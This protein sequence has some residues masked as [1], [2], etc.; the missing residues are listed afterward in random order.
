[1]ALMAISTAAQEVNKLYLGNISCM[2]GQTVDLAFFV[3][4]TSPNITAIQADITLPKGM[5]MQ[6]AES[7]ATLEESRVSDHRVKVQV[8]SNVD[9]VYRY[10]VMLLSPSNSTILANKGKVF[11]MQTMV[12]DA[13]PM[14]EGESYPILMQGVV[15]SN[16]EGQ[17]IVTAYEGGSIT[18]APS[19]DFTVSDVQLT[20]VNDQTGVTALSPGDNFTLSR[21]VNNIGSAQSEAGWNEQIILVSTTTGERCNVATSRHA[22]VRLESGASMEI[23]ENFTVPRLPG[24]DGPFNVLVELTPNSQSG[25]HTEY[26]HNNSA[27]TS[28]TYTMSKR[29]YLSLQQTDIAEPGNGSNRRYYATLE[30]S[31]SRRQQITFDVGYNPTDSRLTL[32]NGTVTISQSSSSA[33]FGFLVADDTQLNGDVVDFG[34]TVAAAAGYGA[35]SVGGHLIDDEHPDLLVSLPKTEFFEGDEFA[36]TITAT[37]APEEDLTIQLSNSAAS[38]FKMP[39]SGVTMAA[40]TTTA[41]AAIKVYDDDV[42]ADVIDVRFT[43][44]ASN[45]NSGHADAILHDNDMPNITLTLNTNAVSEGAGPNAVAC[46]LSR[47]KTNSQLTIEVST[48]DNTQLYSSYRRFTMAKGKSQFPFYLHMLDNGMM[49]GD[50]EVT[51]TVKA[52]IASCGCTTNGTVGG[53]AQ[54]TLTI[55]DDDGPALKLTASTPNIQEGSSGNKFTVSRNNELPSAITV[56]LSTDINNTDFHFPSTVTIPAGERSTTFE[57][58]LDRNSTSGDSRAITLVAKADGYSQGSC[59]VMATDQ[60]LADATI[61]MSV[62]TTEV[63]ATIPSVLNLTLH[64]Q[65]YAPLPAKTPVSIVAGGSVV[66]TVYTDEAFAAGEQTMMPIMLT[67]VLSEN[68]GTVEVFAVVNNGN[69]KPEINYGNNTSEKVTV[70][71]LPLLTT[72]ELHTDK[73]VYTS[74]ETVIISGQTE[75]RINREVDL[76][77]YIVQGGT[78]LPIMTKT[79]EEGHFRVEWTPTLGM[80][81]DFGIGACM[82]GEKLTT[83]STTIKLYGMRRASGTFL[84]SEMEVNEAK[85]GH[86]EIVNP[87]TMPLTNIHATVS[88]LANNV[89]LEV[90]D[91]ESL[92]PNETKVMNYR[93]TG[94]APSPSF[95]EWQTADLRITSAEG[96]VLPQT[97][98][99]VIYPAVPQLKATISSINTTMIKDETRN[100]EFTIYNEGRKETGEINVDVGNTQWLSTATPRRMASLAPGESATVVLQMRPTPGMEL[101]SI[102]TGNIYLSAANGSGVSIAMRV[103]CVSDNT[104]TLVVDVWDEFTANTEEAPHVSGATVAVLHPVTQKLL[105]QYVTGDDGLATFEDLPEGKYLVKVT[106]PKHESYSET[107]IVSPARTITQRAFIPYSA[108]TIEMVYEPTEVE[109]VYDIVT[110][111]NYETQVPRPVLKMDM[112]EKLMVEELQLPYIYYVTLTN[113]GLIAAKDVKFATKTEWG[114][115]RFTPLI[116]GPWEILPQQSVIIPVEITGVNDGSAQSRGAWGP[117]RGPISDKI[118]EAGV[119]CAM[120]T[121]ARYKGQCAA[122]ATNSSMTEYQVEKMMQVNEGCAGIADLVDMISYAFTVLGFSPSGSWSASA[123]TGSGSFH[124]QGSGITSVSCDPCLNDKSKEYIEALTNMKGGGKREMAES[125]GTLLA[126]CP[127]PPPD[128]PPLTAD[129]SRIKDQRHSPKLN[130]GVVMYNTDMRN[131]DNGTMMD[132]YREIVKAI[133]P[134]EDEVIE[135][136]GLVNITNAT[137]EIPSWQPSYLKAWMLNTGIAHDLNYHDLGYIFYVMGDTRLPIIETDE[138][139]AL[140][141]LFQ[142]GETPSDEQ[143]AALHPTALDDEQYAAVVAHLQSFSSNDFDKLSQLAARV[144]SDLMEINRKGYSNAKELCVAEADQTLEGLSSKQSSVCASV[145]LQISQRLT[146]TRQAVRGTLTVV[147]GSEDQPMSDIRLNLVVTDP[148]GN[149]ATPHIMEIHTESIN[150][151]TGELD[152]HSGW[153]LAAKQTG[154]AKIIF[155][156]TK[157]AA[158]TEPL[159]YTFAGTITFIDP[160][161]GLEMT[162]ELETERLTVAPSPDLDLTYFMQRD[163]L[164]DDPLTPEVE[165]Q[166]PS[167]FT[168]LINNKGYGD[169]TKVKMVTNQPEIIENEKGLL[170]DFEIISSQL[171]GGDK[172]LAMGSSVATDFGDIPAHSQAYAQWWMTSTLT[173]HF[174]D[175]SVE[176]THVTSYDNPDLSLLDEVTIH[177]LIHQIVIPGGEGS[178]PPLIGF[179]ANDEEDANDLPDQLYLSNGTKQ[180]VHQAY[181]AVATRESDTQ[182]TITANVNTAGWNYGSLTD[183]TGGSRKLLTVKRRDG[184]LL[185]AENFWQTDR[186]LRDGLQPLYENRIHFCDEMPIDGETYTVTFEDKPAVVLAVGSVSGIPSSDSFTREPVTEVVVTFNKPINAASFT[187]EDLVVMHEG[188]AVDLSGI[189]VEPIDT[190]NETTFKIGLG[191]ITTLD[192]YY[193]LDIQTAGISDLEGFFGEAGKKCSWIQLTDGKAN[194][195]MKVTPEGAGTVAPGTSKQDFNGIVDIAALPAEGYNF[196]HWVK[197][198]ALL[199][200]Q[201]SHSYQMAGPAT[202]TA[203][204]TPKQYRLIVNYNQDGGTIDGGSGLY[205][206]NQTVTLKA[207]AK[208]GYYFAGW[209][210]DG[211]IV[212]QDETLE[213]TIKKADAYEAVFELLS[214]VQA[215]LS[216]LNTKDENLSFFHNPKG[217]YYKVTLDRVLTKGQWNTFCVPFDI[218]EQQINKTWGYNTM[219]VQLKSVADA[220]LSFEYAWN[221]KAGV[222][223]LV[224]PER[225]VEH[226]ELEYKGNL[227]LQTDPLPSTYDNYTFVGNYGPHAW[228]ADGTEWY[229]GVKRGVLF[230]ASQATAHLNGFRAYFILPADGT[231]RLSIMGVA[232]DGIG[233]LPTAEMSAGRTAVY[234]VQGLYMGDDTKTLP[235][236]LYIVNG[237]KMVVK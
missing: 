233:E 43:A 169:A 215:D 71:V 23:T 217:E 232:T 225:T 188:E 194:L 17:N 65:G 202:L 109:D 191:S 171:N 156:P 31:G 180:T 52:Y 143:L 198:E 165:P 230:Q 184:T 158:P 220:T 151:F 85:N 34:F 14:T 97:I 197:D 5:T 205:D 28:G 32:D 181:S 78:R 148:D 221:I 51:V 33:S 193:S 133:T 137:I 79:D 141:A 13:A 182:Y 93:L 30:R 9:N 129:G 120:G 124:E 104:G 134:I 20:A 103:E 187:S 38:R 167:Q 56:N 149:V 218:S 105:R 64:N 237:K 110:T 12:A 91:I 140:V 234:N 170:V 41:T 63:Y 138:A 74:E 37:R 15:L 166:V 115:Y 81:G 174:T 67:A 101:N 118:N 45:Y 208:K 59:W 35:I 16:Q 164:G 3:D 178:T 227:N 206:Y 126:P 96:A 223:Y 173:G 212:S 179:M 162:R 29:L 60:T 99:Y 130:E 88:G 40:G 26:Q 94:L 114:D 229:Y 204:F 75:G 84:A 108:I 216:E 98:Y 36:I 131:M 76:E 136:P 66:R 61:E 168:L 219:L 142:E 55:V 27:T 11:S 201:A 68:P 214:F 226:P 2:K 25:E 224:K 7:Y 161:T 190:G 196:S 236:G 72:T 139:K 152:F 172:T 10:R 157:Y 186:T 144:Q 24:I 235:A 83:A 8:L 199:S 22:D 107:V 210:H 200:D 112:P 211:G 159:L 228:A 57:V 53:V 135:I 19:P 185:P 125:A 47:D 113:V 222:P 58:S 150:G 177:E 153:N 54:Q 175:Y 195:T 48:S 50:R 123:P 82:P 42:V 87:G 121:L 154:E 6:T 155:I 132:C 86:I 106:H 89:E 111:V 18:I 117:M 163:I 189:T 231:A 73:T 192:G 80:A 127:P 203:V 146:M 90:E 102:I 183:P 145:K 213:L 128:W 44:A 49:D 92:G 39:P 1:M 4:N 160:F 176:A 46:T 122:Q 69:V 100:Y 147:N 209:K 70:S 77:V 95:N 21:K 119:E 116:E 62:E 207:T